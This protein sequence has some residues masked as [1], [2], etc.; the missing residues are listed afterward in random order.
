MAVLTCSTLLL[1]LQKYPYIQMYTEPV[2]LKYGKLATK[3]LWIYGYFYSVETLRSAD[4][5]THMGP[6]VAVGLS[7]AM[8]ICVECYSNLW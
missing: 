1:T 8:A 4:R 2:P 6:Q 7:F 3:Y 5:L